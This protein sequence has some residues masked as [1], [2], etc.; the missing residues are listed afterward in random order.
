MC[1]RRMATRPWRSG[2]STRTWRSKRPARRIEDLRSVGGADEH[3]ARA[4]VE[5]VQLHEELVQGLLL[6]V[7]T[8]HQAGGAAGAAE[9]V[10]LVDEDDARRLRPGLLEQVADACGADA[11]EHLHE[12]A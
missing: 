12:L 3:D 4:L 10:Q 7:V 6:L 2:R 5:A 11:D 9:R 1:T 8:A